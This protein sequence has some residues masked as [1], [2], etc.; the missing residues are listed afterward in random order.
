MAW[1]LWVCLRRITACAGTL[2]VGDVP[3]PPNG[4]PSD[5]AAAVAEATAAAPSLAGAFAVFHDLRR[6]PHTATPPRLIWACQRVAAWAYERGHRLTAVCYAEAA[7]AIEPTSAALADGAG[8]MCRTCGFVPRAE[9]WYDRAVGLARRSRSPDEYVTACLGWG[10]LLRDRGELRRALPKIKRAGATARTAGMKGRAAEAVHDVFTIEMLLENYP[11]AVA[12][13]RRAL[14]LYPRHHRRYPYMAADFAALLVRRGLFPEALQILREVQNRL[15]SPGEQLQVWGLV[16]WA[17]GGLP[18]ESSL[19]TR[20]VEI[21]VT[22]AQIHPY[23]APGA[24]Y[25]LAQGARLRSDWTLALQLSERAR[26]LAHESDDQATYKVADTLTREL[27]L[28][29]IGVGE[30]AADDAAAVV[31]RRIASEALK[32][33]EAWRGP[34]WRPR[35]SPPLDQ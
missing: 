35:S 30:P 4:R 8:R 27:H 12:F 9:L 1:L 34:T 17:A 16:G 29:R 20:A 5:D 26:N 13:A 15:T 3:V 24:V 19:F 33:L 25:G 11:R 31:L 6:V 10:N 32:R 2:A 28:Q 21:V 22:G 18:S 23:P 7:A 14:A